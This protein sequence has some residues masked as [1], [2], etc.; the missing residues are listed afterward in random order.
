M[1]QYVYTA[2]NAAGK[3]RKGKINALS[4][5]AAVAELK[6]KGLFPTSIKAA[7]A[8]TVKRYLA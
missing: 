7:V 4:E 6:S 2:M 3:T 1:P 8:A 5:T